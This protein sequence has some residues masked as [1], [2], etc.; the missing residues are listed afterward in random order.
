[1]EKL[2]LALVVFRLF[3]LAPSPSGSILIRVYYVKTAGN[4]G[5]SGK[6]GLDFIC[7]RP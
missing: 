2:Y 6:G 4:E 7:N 5:L 3:L 1:M